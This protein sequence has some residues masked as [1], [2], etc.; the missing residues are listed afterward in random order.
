MQINDLL[1][2]AMEL[3]R[4]HTPRNGATF[5]ACFTGSTSLDPCGTVLS[6]T[7]LWYQTPPARPED[8]YTYTIPIS[9]FMGAWLYWLIPTAN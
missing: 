7:H 9:Y 1:P 5:A 2:H 3:S 4:P 8:P 6:C